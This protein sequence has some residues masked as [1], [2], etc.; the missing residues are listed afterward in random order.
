MIIVIAKQNFSSAA[1]RVGQ[2]GVALLQVL[3]LG[4]IIS[5]LA[6]RFTETARDQIEIAEQ[7]ETRARAQLEAYSA[8]NEV[9]FFQLS[10]SVEPRVSGKKDFFEGSAQMSGAN[11]N[12][13]DFSWSDG[14][15]VSLQDLNGVLPQIFPQHPLWR[16]LLV[17]KAISDEEIARY[18]GVWIDLQDHD[19]NSWVIGN[20]EPAS[21]PTG[22]TYPNGMAQND[23][24]M[25]WVFSDQPGLVAELVGLSDVHGTYNTNPLNYPEA[26]LYALFD[27]NIAEA[28][29]SLRDEPRVNQASLRALLPSD[30]WEDYIFAHNS[31]RLK[32]EVAVELGT[33]VWREKRIIHLRAGSE[34]PFQILRSN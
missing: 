32:I 4:A 9:I 30:L 16:R 10:T 11:F 27:S 17:R 5:L 7:F 1:S 34:P 29:I 26:L 6:I 8:I 25:R 24:L 19:L 13:V 28:F 21:L 15:S 22:Q 20:V 18:L 33:S 31:G 2:S 12:G 3:L 14:V 23:N